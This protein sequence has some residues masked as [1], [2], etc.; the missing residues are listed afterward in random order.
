MPITSFL[1]HF[2]LLFLLSPSLPPP[3]LSL[4]PSLPPLS[5]SLPPSLPP[6]LFLSPSFPPPFPS[7]LSLPLSLLFPFSL[8]LSLLLLFPS[9]PLFPFFF[10]LSL[11][12]SYL[13]FPL[14]LSPISYYMYMYVQYTSD[15][16]YKAHVIYTRRQ[17][18]ANLCKLHEP[19]TLHLMCT[20]YMYT[21]N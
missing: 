13:S 18:L 15:A 4:P 1:L 16:R 20:V 5:P 2:S 17:T 8:S 3:S 10:P 7:P 19:Y 6:S 21:H 11:L 14:P 12:P 9:L